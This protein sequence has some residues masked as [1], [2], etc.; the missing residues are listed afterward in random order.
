MN[1]TRLELANRRAVKAAEPVAVW[2]LEQRLAQS[3][4]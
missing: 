1:V 3:A 2:W 4:A